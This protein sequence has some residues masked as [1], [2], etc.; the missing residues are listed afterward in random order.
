MTSDG[1]YARPEL[2]VEP[3]W[4]IEH[5]NDPNVRVIDCATLEAY[6]RAHIPGAV[7]LPVHIYIKDPTDETFVMQPQQFAQGLGRVRI[8][9][10]HEDAAPHPGPRRLAR[11][12]RQQLLRRGDPR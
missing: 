5:A 10:D 2:L 9:F 3:D 1:G 6:R 4:L 12:A 7:G 8:V 11:A